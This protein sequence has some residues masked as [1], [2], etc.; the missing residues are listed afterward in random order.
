MP[1][2]RFAHFEPA[3]ITKLGRD[4]VGKL[5]W[6]AMNKKKRVKRA[7]ELV[8]D[9]QQYASGMQQLRQVLGNPDLYCWREGQPTNFGQRAVPVYAEIFDLEPN[10]SESAQDVL[11]YR[12][13]VRIQSRQE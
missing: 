9:P 6:N 1:F 8:S 4:L 13:A 10:H 2:D 7:Y 3:L 5:A 12:H 11:G